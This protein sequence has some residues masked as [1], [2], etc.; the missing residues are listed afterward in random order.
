[1]PKKRKFFKKRKNI[2][3]ANQG[4][5]SNKK[6]PQY[7]LTKAVLTSLAKEESP[8]TL[9]DIRKNLAE[10]APSKK[11]MED[12]IAELVRRREIV[13]AGK[14]SF[15]LDNRGSIF[16]GKVEKH[17]RGFGFVTELKPEKTATFSR[18]PYLSVRGI[19][20]ANHGDSVL[21]RITSVRRDGRPEAELVAILERFSESLTGYYK[22]GNPARVV[23]EDP[24]YPSNITVIDSVEEIIPAN[25]VVIITVLPA[26]ADEGHVRGRITE[27]LGSAKDIDVQMRMVI[28]K[29]SLP[30]VF[31][32]EVEKEAASLS[33]KGAPSDDRLDLRDILHVTIDGETAK[34]FDDAV[35]VEK[36][37]RGYRLYVSIADVSHFVRP[38]SELDKEAYLRGT[39]VYF[40]GR[41][42]P[43]LPEKLSN[44]LCSLVPDE[45]RLSFSAILDFDRQGNLTAKK[46]GKSIIRSKQRFTYTT[47]KKILIDK[48]RETRSSHKPFLTPLKWAEELARLLHKKRMARGSIGF[49]IPEPE[50]F[51]KEDGTIE[52]IKRKERN[53]A[54][55]IIEE[56]MLCANEAVAKTF[57]DSDHDFVYR[58]HEKPSTEK[59]EEF[60][61]F[62]QTL[63]I[64][65]P[66]VTAEPEWFAKVLDVVNAT[67]AEYVVNNLLLRAMQQA[68]YDSLN[69]GHFGL[70]ASDYTHFTSPIR[71]YPD[72][73]V[74][75]L[76]QGLLNQKK[77]IVGKK[78]DITLAE[79]TRHLS[80][81]ERAAVTAERDIVDRL[82]I[83]FMERFVGDTFKAVISGVSDNVLFI[84]LMDLFISGSIAISALTDDY[85]LYDGKRYRLIGEITAKTY[86]LGDV[87]SV[88]LV[89]VDRKRKR[90]NFAPEH[91]VHT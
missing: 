52:T 18:D 81:R 30:H 61:S 22:P 32:P 56:F 43:M 16:K 72:L 5:E 15:R 65:L 19:G 75:R 4:R 42:I 49:N 23:P 91:L 12:A 57:S 46:F 28:E 36:N 14:K 8:L 68:R 34:D 86:Q 63:G 6:P 89:D 77:S 79:M 33:M 27:V 37:R 7:S 3:P 85:Y 47:V 48:D 45:D 39:S 9:N 13:A 83:F 76:L 90:L 67:P 66:E 60:A 38:G 74:H 11:D 1:M 17:P 53:F 31:P 20:T 2:G 80:E 50:I 58:I 82:K 24:R 78:D 87:L 54:H 35:A 40:P 41:V 29:H 59:V 51:L 64:D 26:I 70:A 88:S 44:D 10:A 55:Q 62:A 25:H 84:E 69:K 73:M 71:R 21:I